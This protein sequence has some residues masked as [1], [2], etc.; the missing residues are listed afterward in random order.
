MAQPFKT[1]DDQLKADLDKAFAAYRQ[2]TD[3]AGGQATQRIHDAVALAFQRLLKSPTMQQPTKHDLGTP[4]GRAAQFVEEIA[5]SMP[6]TT[7][8]LFQQSLAS[9][10]YYTGAIDADPGLSES[11]KTW[12]AARLAQA[13]A[14]NPPAPAPTTVSGQPII[15]LPK[16]DTAAITAFYGPPGDAGAANRTWANFPP[17]M[18]LYDRDGQPLKDYDKD[19]NRWGDLSGLHKK[20]KD[21]WDAAWAEIERSFTEAE[22]RDFGGTVTDG[23]YNPRP[24]KGGSTPSTHAWGIAADFNA[25]ENRFRRDECTFPD[26]WFDIWERHGFLSGYRAWGHDAMHIQAAIPSISAGSYYSTHG[27]PAWIKQA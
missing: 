4:E 24:K 27:L 2:T 13:A 9:A 22:L 15:I 17:Y 14:K 19:G 1:M 5:A 18:R 21:R 16:D 3:T 7:V 12:A 26:K 25:S 8:K 10:G 6:R 23:I 20:L 11:G